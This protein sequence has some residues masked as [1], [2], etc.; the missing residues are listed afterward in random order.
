MTTTT[1]NGPIFRALA[2]LS[3]V[4]PVTNPLAPQVW[5]N[6]FFFTVRLMPIR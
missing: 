4:V 1:T 6:D 3:W 2:K 5:G